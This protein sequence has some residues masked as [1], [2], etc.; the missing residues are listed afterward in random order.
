MKKSEEKYGKTQVYRLY[1]SME[2]IRKRIRQ[3]ELKRRCI[4]EE[5][6]EGFGNDWEAYRKAIKDFGLIDCEKELEGIKSYVQA[7]IDFY[8]GK[9]DTIPEPEEV[10]VPKSI[11]LHLI[12][13]MRER[14]SQD[15]IRRHGGNPESFTEDYSDSFDQLV[16]K[17]ILSQPDLEILSD[18]E[19]EKLDSKRIK[20]LNWLPTD[21]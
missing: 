16:E 1:V 18:E 6:A 7:R 11:G 14:H 17:R 19:L 2:A 9:I 10:G 5:V 8:E 20:S 13:A 21:F 4:L 12:N 15:C 3:L